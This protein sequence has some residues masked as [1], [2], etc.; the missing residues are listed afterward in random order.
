[1]SE[2]ITDLSGFTFLY[3]TAVP[4]GNYGNK[5]N[6]NLA[7]TDESSLINRMSG[8]WQASGS[9]YYDSESQIGAY[10]GYNFNSRIILDCARFYIGRYQGQNLNLTVDIQ[11][12]DENNEWQTETQVIVSTSL[13]YPVNVFTVSLNKPCYGIRWAHIT[14]PQKSPANNVVFFGMLLYKS[15][16]PPPQ[17]PVGDLSITLQY[18]ASEANKVDKDLTEIATYTGTLRQETSIIDPVFLIECDLTDVIGANY[19]TVPVFNRSYFIKNIRSIRNNL[20]EFTC[21]VDVLSSFKTELRTNNA[22]INRSERN[23]NLYINDGSLKTKQNPHITTQEF[24]GGF[25]PNWSFILV[26]AG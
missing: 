7:I 1:M 19:L 3:N 9:A 4:Y 22:I 26:I 23:W 8:G 15:E 6:T 20:V 10:G 13:P 17:P 2:Q 11:L 18:S 21:H 14:P 24:S 16:T 25:G 12:L 5:V